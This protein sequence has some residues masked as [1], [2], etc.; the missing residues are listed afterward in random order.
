M[1]KFNKTRYGTEFVGQ[2][3][4]NIHYRMYKSGKKWV[5]AGIISSGL[6]FFGAGVPMVHAET[7]DEG[8]NTAENSGTVAD[9]AD[10]NVLDFSQTNSTSA[11]NVKQTNLGDVTDP[12]VIEKAKTAA[13]AEYQ[14]TKTPQ[15]ITAQSAVPTLPTP[16][17][18]GVTTAINNGMQNSTAVV[19]YN[20]TTTTSRDLTKP[21]QVDISGSFKAGDSNCSST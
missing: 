1:R 16:T 21:I 11:A 5:F 4:E 19:A 2:S 6:F 3:D 8:L 13:D 17:S 7:T 15:L 18:N 10:K 12:A 14:A 20:D 9:S